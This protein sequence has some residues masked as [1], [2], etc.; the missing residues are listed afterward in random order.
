[1]IVLREYSKKICNS[2]GRSL[3]EYDCRKSRKEIVVVVVVKQSRWSWLR[4]F[5]VGK[6]VLG[7]RS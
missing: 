5:N 4:E 3:N 1:M 6:N 7:S 2:R